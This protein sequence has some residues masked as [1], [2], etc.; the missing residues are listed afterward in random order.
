[1]SPRPSR[2]QIDPTSIIAGIGFVIVLLF[3][4]FLNGFVQT[5]HSGGSAAVPRD[6]PLQLAEQA[7]R[8]G[9]DQSAAQIFSEL[10]D[11]NNPTAQYWLAHMTELGLAVPHDTGKAIGLY[12][13]AANA[14]V[15]A[16]QLRLGEIYLRGD[17]VPPDFAQAKG[18]L[19]RSALRGDPRAAME[20]GR[21]YQLGL[22]MPPDPVAAY[23]WSE[24]AALEGD[25]PARRERDSSLRS[26]KGSDRQTAIARAGE[27]LS[28]IKQRAA[29]A[30][31]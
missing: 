30:N 22:G 4:A 7:F 11:K 14:G 1:V 19:E 31:P 21:M 17:T 6:K 2:E 20:L 16:A 9:H 29:Q 15:I 13:K 25:V 12:K 10:A 8:S 28:R 27:I 24:V 18:Y 23:A 26:L 3:G 5:L